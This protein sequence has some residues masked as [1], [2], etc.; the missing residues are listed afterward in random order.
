MRTPDAGIGTLVVVGGCLTPSG[1]GA[2][3][4]E[5][6]DS[7]VVSEKAPRATPE[8]IGEMTTPAYFSRG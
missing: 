6:W 2:T 8:I 4:L 3:P 1:R 7:A 5:W